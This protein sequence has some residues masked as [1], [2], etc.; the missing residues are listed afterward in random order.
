MEV[1]LVDGELSPPFSF[2]S[3]ILEVCQIICNVTAEAFLVTADTGYMCFPHF[4]HF[5]Y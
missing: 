2:L 4:V 1:V 5:F 3:S